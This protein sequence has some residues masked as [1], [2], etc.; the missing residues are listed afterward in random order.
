[1]ERR[2]VMTNETDRLLLLFIEM[3][4][5]DCWLRPGESAEL[6]AEVASLATDFK[7]TDNPDGVTVWPDNKMGL[8]SVW[9][10]DQEVA[11]GYQRPAHWPEG[12]DGS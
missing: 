3:E 1:M 6:R 8:I 2:R 4:G 7:F 12:R 11:I 10:D 9:Q 5:W